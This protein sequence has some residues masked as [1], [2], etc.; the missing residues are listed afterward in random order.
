MPSGPSDRR[1]RSNRR[2]RHRHARAPGRARLRGRAR[3]RLGPLS[4]DVRLPSGRT[5]CSVEEAIAG[6]ARRRRS[7][8][9]LLLGRHRASREL[10]PHAVRGG[11]VVHRQVGRLPPDRRACRS[12]SSAS[13]RTCSTATRS[14]PTR[15]APPCSS[16]AR[17]SRC[18]RPPA[19]PACGSRP[20]SRPPAPATPASS[21][22]RR[23]RPAEGDLAMDWDLDGEEFS[24]EWKLRA[25]TRKIL[26]PARPAAARDVRA[27]PGAGRPRAGRLGRDGGA[28]VART[29]RAEALAASPQVEL[30][31]FPDAEGRGG[32]RH[33]AGGP[34]PSGRG[35]GR[36]AC[37][38]GR[39]DN[40]RKGAALNAVQIADLLL[41]R[42]L[43]AA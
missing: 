12:S 32:P 41:A 40:L 26:E 2:R 38:L 22:C 34:D 37:A 4:R 19:S 29:R 3:V 25:E 24:E 1:R 31:D 23:L 11:A 7:R 18:A 16:P 5:S 36:G 10:V 17:S 27:C 8:P 42:R 20:T 43:L 15:T 30:M 6:R 13:T 35:A 21:A 28:A 14:S 33:G 9:L 39:G